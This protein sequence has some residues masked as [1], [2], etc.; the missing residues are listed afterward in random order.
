[1]SGWLRHLALTVKS[2]T[3][4]GAGVLAWGLVAIVGGAATLGFFIF[5]AFIA[6]TERYGPLT[7]ALALGGLFLLITIVASIC[8]LSSQRRTIADAKLALAARS[9]T[10]WLDP[11]L[12]GA[13]LQVGRAIGWRR[14]VPLAAVGVL[15]AGL[16]KEWFPR[17]RT[18]G[19]ASSPMP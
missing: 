13:G 17:N 18:A 9:S 11:R 1:M 16:A 5:A 4:L 7:A 19:E 3:G 14:L 6:L 8:C 10:L 15:A 2:K 12:L